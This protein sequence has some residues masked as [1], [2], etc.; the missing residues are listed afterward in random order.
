MTAPSPGP[1]PGGAA[2][3]AGSGTA[4]A[5]ELVVEGGAPLRGTV[6]VPGDKSVSHRALLLA[7]LAEGTSKVSGRSRGADLEHT[8]DAVRALGAGIRQEGPWEVV[9]GGRQRLGEPARSIDCG[10]SGTGVRL[11]AG[12]VAGLDGL[13]VLEGDASVA[14]RPMDRVA[15]PLREMGAVVDGRMGGT[16]VPLVVRGGRLE[17]IEHAPAVAS[18]QVKGAVLLAGLAARGETVIHERSATRAHSEELLAL[19]GADLE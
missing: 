12:L 4:P 5:G 6:R 2:P 1:A 9:T 15:Q 3:G 16:R 11:L 13:F 14:S 10:N 17:G 19:A 7:A 8:A 18:A